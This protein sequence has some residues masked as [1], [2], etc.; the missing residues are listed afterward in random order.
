MSKWF[1]Q[2]GCSWE[3]QALTKMVGKF[4]KRILKDFK[5]HF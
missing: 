1:A 4:S 3:G 5:N 2:F